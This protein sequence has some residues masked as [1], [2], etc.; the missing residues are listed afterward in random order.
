M[1]QPLN[2]VVAGAGHAA[3]LALARLGG[4]PPGTAITLVSSG[5]EAHYS[6]MVPGW[7]EGLY[8][9]DDLVVPLAPFAA[10]HGVRFVE[11]EV[12]GADPH[13]LHLSRGAPLAFDVLVVNTGSVT[14]RPG[15]LGDPRVIPAKPFP[16]LM[17]GLAD[18]R[19][20]S[21]AFAV[22]GAGVAGTELALA[23][24]TRRPDAE[25]TLL[26]RADTHLPDL[27]RAVAARVARALADRGVTLRLGAEV[28]A[29]DGDALR[30]AD[31]SGV[32]AETVLAATGPAPPPW[33]AASPFAL[34]P[35]GYLAVDERMRS[36]SHPFVLAVGD[37]ATRQDDPR[38]KA[39]V[40][41]VRASGPLAE[42]IRRLGRGEPLPPVRLQRR[43]L[44]LLSTGA[45]SAIGTRNGFTLEGG[46]VWRLKDR[47]DRNFVDGLRRAAKV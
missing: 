20:M 1:A 22:V 19:D 39:G 24:A 29:L 11:A 43:A 34:T 40:F 33:L 9:R 2:I 13:A 5:A 4:P 42:A 25:V 26:D 36:R 23:L 37:A 7:I 10:A 31:G 16:A 15:P 32:A 45:R 27:P 18:A 17:A 46:A 47:L 21:G 35:A 6:G 8:R 41:S 44:V 30:L 14:A 3:M 38:P 12:V 28:E